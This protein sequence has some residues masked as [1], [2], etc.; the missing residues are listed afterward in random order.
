[1]G[2]WKLISKT[3]GSSILYKVLCGI[4]FFDDFKFKK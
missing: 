1:M 4:W 2:R 3:K